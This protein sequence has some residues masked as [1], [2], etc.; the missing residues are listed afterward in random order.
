[1]NRISHIKETL[2]KNIEDNISYEKL[3]F[4]L[5]DYNSSDG[6]EEWIKSKLAKYID[7]GI[8]KYHRTSEPKSF[9]RSH[10]RNVALKLGSG[11]ILC[12]LDADNFLGND[13]A[14]YVNYNFSFNKDVFLTS[15]F[16][17]GSYGKIC[18]KKEHFLK[19]KGYDERMSGW[20]YED[21]D[22]YFRLNLLG[23]NQ[24]SF[25][26][27]EFTEF[28]DHPL[29]DSFKNDKNISNITNILIDRISQNKTELIFLLSDGKFKYVSVSR[30]ND[31]IFE[32]PKLEK[33]LEQGKYQLLNNLLDLHFK[34]ETRKNLVLT[35][36]QNSFISDDLKFHSLTDKILINRLKILLT[37][38]ENK[39]LF[40]NKKNEK[41]LISNKNIWGETLLETFML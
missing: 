17:N 18:V 33:P 30:Q 1:M 25:F 7:N 3:E 24:V 8:L 41:E 38:I 34:S 39:A 16:K 13:F 35:K 21:D 19:I 4:I 14:S 5:L 10:S 26:E 32:D 15:G 6:L 23:I 20:G 37:S 2:L 27:K 11:D 12:N 36:H 22:L 29:E 31:L 28:I 9:H 40:T